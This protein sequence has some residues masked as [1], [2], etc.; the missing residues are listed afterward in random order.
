[1]KS[2][3]FY[4][5]SIISNNLKIY[6]TKCYKTYNKYIKLHDYIGFYGF[7]TLCKQYGIM[8][9]LKTFLVVILLLRRLTR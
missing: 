3:D 2:I 1:M 8:Q 5:E 7:W 6:I 4:L 9:V